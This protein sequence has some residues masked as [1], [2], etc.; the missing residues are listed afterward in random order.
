FNIENPLN[1]HY[2][3]KHDGFD[4]GSHSIIDPRVFDSGLNYMAG[5]IEGYDFINGS[6]DRLHVY[7]ISLLINH[8]GI[9]THIK[10]DASNKY[11]VAIPENQKN[12]FDSI[13][14]VKINTTGNEPFEIPVVSVDLPDTKITREIV[15]K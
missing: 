6:Y 10:Q 2:R 3:N 1:T 5:I 12:K 7:Y 13:F 14:N 4:V 11:F 15:E 8:F 9:V